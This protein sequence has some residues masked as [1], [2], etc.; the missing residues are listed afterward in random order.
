M[1]IV[2]GLT[3]PL[4]SLPAI[5]ALQLVHRIKEVTRL[6]CRLFVGLSR[7]GETPRVIQ[8]RAPQRVPFH[9]RE[10]VSQKVSQVYRDLGRM[11]NMDVIYMSKSNWFST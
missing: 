10:K 6:H 1:Y 8:V 9:L 7:T 3:Q 11:E 5:E 4:L 2:A